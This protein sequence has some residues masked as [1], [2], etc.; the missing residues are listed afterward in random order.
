MRVLGWFGVWLVACGPGS[1][2]VDAGSGE[3]DGGADTGVTIDASSELDAAIDASSELDADVERD[4]G[5]AL[6]AGDRDAGD[7][8]AGNRDAGNRDAGDELDAGTD[9]GTDVGTDA[10]TDAGTDAGTDT[11]PACDVERTFSCDVF[12]CRLD[13]ICDARSARASVCV[14]LP[15]RNVCTP[16]ST[17]ARAVESCPRGFFRELEGSSTEG[18][19][20][21]CR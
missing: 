16:C 1:A 19:T 10:R 5:D 17:Q 14:D 9:A 12:E 11:G 7:R 21:R 3:V 13:Q 18:C 2:M 20:V 4:A 8:D 6:D 15:P